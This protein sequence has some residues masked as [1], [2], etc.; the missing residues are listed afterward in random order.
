MHKPWG[1]FSYYLEH[2]FDDHI[3]ISIFHLVSSFCQLVHWIFWLLASFVDASSP[4]HFFCNPLILNI[5]WF[6]PSI[7]HWICAFDFTQIMRNTHMLEDLSLYWPSR[8]FAQFGNGCQW[9]RS[10]EGLREFGYD[11][12]FVLKHLPFML[13]IMLLCIVE[14][15]EEIPL[16]FDCQ[17]MQW[18]SSSFTHAYIMGEFA[19][20]IQLV[21]VFKFLI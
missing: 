4:C 6:P 14:Y 8:F 3:I 16:G 9:G 7:C 10:L 17:Y 5:V 12:C 19:L 2:S 15:I 21:W 1:V 18:N 11:Y 13:C 20:C